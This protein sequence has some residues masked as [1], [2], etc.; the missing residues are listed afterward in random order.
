MTSS[1]RLAALT[2]LLCLP[3]LSVAADPQQASQPADQAAAPASAPA[4]PSA[5]APADSPTAATPA[6]SGQPAAASPA[7]SSKIGPPPAGK[8]QV[9]FFRERRFAGAALSFMVREGSNELG[10]LG[11]GNYFVATLDPGAHD[12]AVHTENKDTL[13]MEVEAGETY[14][15]ISTISMGFMVGHANISPSDQATFEKDFDS[16]KDSKAN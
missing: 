7:A 12:F 5:Q 9:V 2:A 14:Y 11:S 8:G 1:L 13:H 15:V 4:S 16:L 6:A 3:S 10:K